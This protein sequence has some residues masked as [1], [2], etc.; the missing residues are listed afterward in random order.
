MDINS[1]EYKQEGTYQ[2]R[3]HACYSH[4]LEYGA[5]GTRVARY[6]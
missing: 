1:E 4:S 6:A 2:R 5:E 3:C